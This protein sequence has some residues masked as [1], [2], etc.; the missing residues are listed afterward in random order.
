MGIISQ[1]R[2]S[3]WGC[4]SVAVI[5]MFV[6]VDNA[7]AVSMLR[8]SSS[9]GGS[10]TVT[11][12][13]AND[14]NSNVG[15]TE[16]D[17]SLTGWNVNITTGITHPVLGSSLS[18]EFD[19]NSVNVSQSAGTLTIAFTETDF[20]NSSAFAGGGGFFAAIGGTTV[21]TVSYQTYL[22][23]ANTP[24]AQTTLLGNVGPFGTNAFSGTDSGSFAGLNAPFS[25]TSVV[26]ITHSGA[27]ISSFDANRSLTGTPG[28]APVPEPSSMLLLGSGLLGLGYW[29]WNKKKE[30]AT[31]E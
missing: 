2:R 21:G 19:L 4:V 22:D 20:G 10:V 5:S 18:P 26:T 1:S 3:L 13:G 23:S 8:L 29:R 6:L 24:F 27:G 15:V 16:F 17:G 14:D 11:D 31:K 28:G 25:L 7:Q 9:Q 12:Q 30:T